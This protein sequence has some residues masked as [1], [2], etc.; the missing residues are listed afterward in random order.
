MKKV[1]MIVLACSFIFNL[2]L[3]GKTEFQLDLTSRYIWRGFDMLPD[4]H[5]AFQPSLT[6]FFKN[7]GF[8]LNIWGS[9]A[10]SD[11]NIFRYVDE[12]DLT[13][14]YDFKSGEEISLSAGVTLYGFWFARD[15]SFENNTSPEIYFSATFNKLPLTPCLSVY[16]DLNLGDGFYIQLSGE[17]AVKLTESTQLNLTASLGYNGKQ[18]INKSGFSDLLMGAAIPIKA[19]KVTI[20]PFVNMAI[21]FMEE[22]NRTN[23]IWFGISLIF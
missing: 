8:S 7:S 18:Y 12:V 19:K 9:F 23:E 16:Y 4:N 13:L 1:L 14:A 2:S 6:Y 15:F 22:V 10:L 17:Q 20:S 21:I 5:P 11:R 3:Q